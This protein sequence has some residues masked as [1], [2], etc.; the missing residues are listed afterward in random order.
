MSDSNHESIPTDFRVQNMASLAWQNKCK[1]IEDKFK[2]YNTMVQITYASKLK[3]CQITKPSGEIYNFSTS[4]CGLDKNEKYTYVPT[5]Q[6]LEFS[7]GSQFGRLTFSAHFLRISGF[8][9]KRWSLKAGARLVHLRAEQDILKLIS[10]V[11]LREWRKQRERGL[12]YPNVRNGFIGLFIL[13]LSLVSEEA[14]IY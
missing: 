5:S 11:L 3:W 6:S 8:F 9:G 10:L 12:K 7:L 1:E 14:S 4:D 13:V 2:G